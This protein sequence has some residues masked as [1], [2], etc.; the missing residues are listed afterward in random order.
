M[1][2]DKQN[3]FSNAQAVTVTAASESVIDLGA[4][5]AKVVTPNEKPSHLFV[6][7][8]TAF[9]SGTSLKVGLEMDDNA[10]FSSATTVFETAAIGVASLVAGYKFSLPCLPVGMEQFA[11]LYYT[12]VGTMSAGKITAGLVLDKQTNA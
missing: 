12:V 7:V 6:Q 1:I 5:G 3:L 8:V 2:L 11:R 4:E 10:S 9:A